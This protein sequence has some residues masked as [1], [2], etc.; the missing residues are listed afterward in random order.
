M[1]AG[2]LATAIGALAAVAALTGCA[3]EKETAPPQVP[4][5]SLRLTD[6]DISPT[7]PTVD[8]PGE[9]FLRIRNDGRSVHVLAVD[10]PEGEARTDPIKPGS[11]A[12]LRVALNEPGTYRMYCPLADH[13]E[14][15]MRGSITVND[16]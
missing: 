3:S 1:T 7:S 11:G 12:T 9:V 4:T 13:A 10:G 15:G 14:R 2:R 5:L 6:F 16:G 8:K